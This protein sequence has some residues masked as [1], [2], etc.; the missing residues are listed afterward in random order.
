MKG[1]ELECG[2]AGVIGWLLATCE[3]F[4]STEDIRAACEARMGRRPASGTVARV[5]DMLR[6]C[7][8]L[9]WQKAHVRRYHGSEVPEGAIVPVRQLNHD[10]SRCFKL[11]RYLL[12]VRRLGFVG[13]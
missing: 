3:D 6:A 1:T 10:G 7:S 4:P 11:K 2:V 8:V 12:P 9:D 13:F 5:L